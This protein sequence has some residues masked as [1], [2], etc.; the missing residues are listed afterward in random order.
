MR[1]EQNRSVSL[2]ESEPLD[3]ELDLPLCVTTENRKNLHVKMRSLP[4]VRGNLFDLMQTPVERLH[5]AGSTRFV[6][7]ALP[8]GMV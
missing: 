5:T 3:I 1:S 6:V 8:K 4:R 7:L 2:H